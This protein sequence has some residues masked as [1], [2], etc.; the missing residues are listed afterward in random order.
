[1]KRIGRIL[2]CLL[3][4]LLTI[5]LQIWLTVPICG[6]AAMAVLVKKQGTGIPFAEQVN[7]LLSLISTPTFIISYPCLMQLWR[8]FYLAF[9]TGKK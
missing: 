2:F 1:M 7:E 3:P 4:L 9:G 6:I 5:I 8:W